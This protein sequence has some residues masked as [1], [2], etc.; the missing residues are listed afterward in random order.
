LFVFYKLILLLSGLDPRTVHPILYF[1]KS[2]TPVFLFNRDGRKFETTTEVTRSR[3][4]W[5]PHTHTHTHTRTQNT[6]TVCVILYEERKIRHQPAKMELGPCLTRSGRTN[7]AVSVMVS[8]GFSCLSVCSFFLVFSVICY[9]AFSVYMLQ[10][11]SSVFL[12]FVQNWVYNFHVRR[13]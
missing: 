2:K 13:D 1:D 6:Y 9:G 3:T 10:P 4:C 5:E 8:P 7:L 11:F 12:Y